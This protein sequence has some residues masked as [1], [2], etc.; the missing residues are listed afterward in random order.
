MAPESETS[1]RIAVPASNWVRGAVGENYFF[2]APAEVE[3]FTRLNPGAH[4]SPA[5]KKAI[6]GPTAAE[7]A[8]TAVAR[9]RRSRAKPDAQKAD[10]KSEDNTV[11]FDAMTLED[12]IAYAEE[13]DVDLEDE[14]D[15][16]AIIAKLK[17][18]EPV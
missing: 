5:P 15:K 8:A 17:A 11:D 14:D 6:A 9:P 4:P 3:E 12:L 1:I 7:E 16:D 18:G 10:D 2:V 13:H